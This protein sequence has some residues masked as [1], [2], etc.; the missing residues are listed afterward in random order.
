MDDESEENHLAAELAE[1]K[2]NELHSWN[3]A[4]AS[5]QKAETWM[6]IAGIAGF[7]ILWLIF[8][9]L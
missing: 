7:F 4:R 9:T 3:I 5:E 8:G 1:A 6:F 2:R